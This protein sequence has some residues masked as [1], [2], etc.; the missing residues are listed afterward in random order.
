[1][2]ARPMYCTDLGQEIATVLYL[3][4]AQAFGVRESD[5]PAPGG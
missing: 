2:L 3:N 5:L 4:E 1:M